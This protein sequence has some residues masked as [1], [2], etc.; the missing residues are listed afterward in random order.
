MVTES[1]VPETLGYKFKRRM[2]GPPLVNEQMQ[3]RA[4]VP[5]AR[6]RR[7]VL[8][9]HLLGRLRHRGDAHRDDPGRRPGRVHAD[10]AD[11]AGDPGRHRAGR[12]VL[13]RGR[14]GLHPGG[15]LLRGGPGELRAAGR[16]GRGRRAAHR[17]HRD[18]RGADRRGQRR[19]RL[20]VPAA[21]QHPVLRAGD[22]AWIS[23]VA[24]WSCA[25]ATCAASGR[26]ARLRAADLPVHRLGHPHDRRRPD[27]RA[28]HRPRARRPVPRSHLP[29][30]AQY[31]GLLS[32]GMLYM[33][34]KAFANGGSSLTGIEAVSNAVSA[35]K[36]PE[37]RN[38]RQIL[39]TQ[40]HRRIP[41]R[42]HLLAGARHARDPV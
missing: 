10:P 33:L 9:R 15:R 32:V 8:R 39:V 28:D 21:G 3:E 29:D 22:P 6:P 1:G 2:L 11:D 40:G 25:S 27:P 41:D 26:R 20:R 38:A 5:A 23:V 35:L 19:D 14:L 7:A 17:L 31:R 30:R 36:P 16:P 13:P 37:G 4:A 18:R 12:A 42:G 34:A 24:C